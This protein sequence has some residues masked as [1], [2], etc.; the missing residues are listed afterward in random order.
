MLTVG[1][2]NVVILIVVSFKQPKLFAPITVYI[3]YTLGETIIVELDEP[4]LHV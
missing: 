4:V 2:L 3:V 1:L